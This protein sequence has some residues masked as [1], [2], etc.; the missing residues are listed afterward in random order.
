MRLAWV[1]RM[2]CFGVE[3][4]G[5]A[6]TDPPGLG[7]ESGELSSDGTVQPGSKCEPSRAPQESGFHERGAV[8]DRVVASQ[9]QD[10]RCEPEVLL[11]EAP[12]SPRKRLGRI[13][14]PDDV[15]PSVPSVRW[16]DGHEWRQDE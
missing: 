13:R 8:I 14:P 1:K 2:T 15:E 4:E 16:W 6:Q 11:P 12:P 5:G 7:R 9:K 3:E 10:P